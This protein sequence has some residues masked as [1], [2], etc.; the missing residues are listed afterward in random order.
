MRKLLL[1]VPLWLLGCPSTG[2]GVDPCAPNPCLGDRSVCTVVD[3]AASCACRQGFDDVAGLCV[4]RGPCANNP[5]TAPHRSVCVASGT[6]AVCQCDQGW[7]DDGSGQCVMAASCDPNPCTQPGRT[8][9][10]E[11]GGVVTCLCSPGFRDDGNGG[12]VS[13]NPCA[14]NPCT[15]P[16]R[17]VCVA[18]GATAIC[19]CDQGFIDDQG[20]C[21]KP[22]SCAPNP[23]TQPNRTVCSVATGTVTCSCDPGFRLDAVGQCVAV[24]ACN[25]NPCTQPHRTACSDVG[26]T[27]V[28]GCDPGFHDEA[29][30]C[31]ANDVCTPNPCTQPHQT[32]CAAGDAGVTCACEPGYQPAANGCELPPPPTC[33]GQHTTGDAFEPDECPSLAKV[34]VPGTPQS[35]TFDPAGDVDFV[36]FSVDAGVVVLLEETGPLATSVSLYDVDGV[37]PLLANQ[38]ERVL[39]KLN[40]AGTYFA[41]VRAQSAS[42]TG[43]TTL[44]LTVT[45]DDFADDRTTTASL[46][47]AM[48]PGTSVSGAFQFTGDT[49]CVAVPVQ[50]G[51]LYTFEETTGSDVYLTVYTATGTYFSTTDTEWLRFETSATETLFLCTRAYNSAAL[52]G[53]GLRVTDEGVDDFADDRT[54]TATLTPVP[55]PGASVTGAFQYPADTDCVRVPV[56]AGRL[57]TFEETTGSDVYLSVYTATGTFIATTDTEW[58]RFETSTTETLVLCTRAYNSAAI[59]GWGLRVTDEGV[60]D[61]ADDRSTT[62][63]LT[64]VAAPGA[65]VSGAFQY[66]ADTDCVAVPVQAGRVYAFEETTAADVYLTVYTATGTYLSTT[67]AE[68]LRFETSASETL[69]LCTRA[70]NSAAI[71]GWALRVTDAGVDD[72][73]DDRSTTATLTPVPAPGASVTGAFQYPA[74]TDCVQVPVQGGRLYTFEETTAADVYLT[75][76]T[77]TGTFLSTTDAEWLRFETST[78]ETLF[79]C[80]RAYNSAAIMGWGLRVTDEGVDDFADDRVGAQPLLPVASPGASVSGAFQYP[81][82]TD[83]VAVPV[84]SGRVY[85]FAETSG[86]DVYLT[87]YTATGTLIPTTDGETLRFKAGVTETLFLCTRAYNSA[88]VAGWSFN[89]TDAGPDDHADTQAGATPLAVDG[90]PVS[91]ELQFSGDLDFFTF[92]SSSV[93][94]LRLMT[95]GVGTTLQVQ[96]STGATV[97]TLSGPGTS[98][99]VLP[100]AGTYFVRVSSSSGLGAYTVAIAN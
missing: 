86:T 55:S 99:F 30:T 94:A 58:L 80:T 60:D 46:T 77:A 19:Q 7:R 28:C 67:D 59:L 13:S 81:G 4:Q 24:M 36:K 51:R 1:V 39:R 96:S 85:G 78:S 44:Q 11:S 70:Y 90:T 56:Q 98:A 89:V 62:A 45:A 10:S 91:G 54:T 76:Y 83:C 95:T 27:A 16:N 69:F 65:S 41:Q 64:P 48:S 40:A 29:G 38:P 84:Q 17:T 12:C 68:S 66:P 57:Y 20:Q 37:T 50:A 88:A 22:P 63:T 35:H 82:D 2:P 42:T 93:L 49:D 23:C 26:G 33:N 32:V 6:T 47:P 100:A 79:L 72:F 73:A 25:P 71:M 52:V 5:C 34:I 15:Q 61:F 43:A 31:V 9:C 87:V 92:T 18:S 14:V 21:V 75:V 53:W 8:V 3:G 74:D 97:A